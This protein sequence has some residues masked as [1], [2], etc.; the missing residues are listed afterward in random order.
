MPLAGLMFGSD[1]SARLEDML[2][3]RGITVWFHW[4]PVIYVGGLDSE[5]PFIDVNSCEMLKDRDFRNAFS[6]A[7]TRK[8]TTNGQMFTI[9]AKDP[10]EVPNWHLL[11]FV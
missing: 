4:L 6:D 1:A 8:F 3:C 11:N 9:W 5:S 2:I 10:G 7:Y